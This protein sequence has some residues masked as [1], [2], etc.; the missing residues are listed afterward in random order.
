MG[1]AGVSAA[2]ARPALYVASSC[3]RYSGRTATRGKPLSADSDLSSGTAADRTVA[4][5]AVAARGAAKRLPLLRNA[6][7]AM[8]TVVLREK[9]ASWSPW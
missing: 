9:S 1:A 5:A 6:T 4:A 8:R 3:C 7:S 2:G